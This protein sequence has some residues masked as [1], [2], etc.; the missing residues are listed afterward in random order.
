MVGVA[1]R[2]DAL[3]ADAAEVFGLFDGVEEVEEEIA[4]MSRVLTET[5]WE[6]KEQGYALRLVAQ[7]GCHGVVEFLPPRG[8]VDRRDGS[9]AG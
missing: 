5:A 2:P 4:A 9:G 3:D 8:V 1:E 6:A 7:E